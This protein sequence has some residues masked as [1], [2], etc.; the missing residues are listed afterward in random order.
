MAEINNHPDCTPPEFS[1]KKYGPARGHINKSYPNYDDLD[2]YNLKWVITNSEI[3]EQVNK[4]FWILYYTQGYPYPVSD[5]A[6][7]AK[8]SYTYIPGIG[9]T[10]NI[11]GYYP[12]WCMHVIV[13]YS[14][15]SPGIENTS[16]GTVKSLFK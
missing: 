4:R 10:T 15:I 6:T 3:N 9:W 8:N 11:S 14:L 5:E 2:V 16:F 13:E 7:N 1:K 12:C